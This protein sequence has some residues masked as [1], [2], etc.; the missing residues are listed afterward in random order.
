[1]QTQCK[2]ESPGFFPP[3]IC[4]PCPLW[5]KRQQQQQTQCAVRQVQNG[6]SR[7]FLK[8]NKLD[9]YIDNF[10]D[11][12]YDDMN[13]LLSMNNNEL[14][15]V[16]TETNIEKPGHIKRFIADFEILKSSSASSSGQ[17]SSSSS[18]SST[19][20]SKDS[21]NQ[22]SCT[23]SQGDVASINKSD[24]GDDPKNLPKAIQDMY[25]PNPHNEQLKFYN[26]LLF[27]LHKSSYDLISPVQFENYVMSQRHQRWSVE[28]E[29]KTVEAF[30]E[31]ATSKESLE[32]NAINIR[33]YTSVD[34]SKF[35]A[36]DT[37]RAE[38]TVEYVNILYSRLNKLKKLVLN[39]KSSLYDSEY[40]VKHWKANELM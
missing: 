15:S 22:E 14:M 25:I 4:F 30:F 39:F 12:G 17:T 24:H 26:A 28:K 36:K 9:V 6:G 27:S 20:T 10:E 18:A 1:M 19:S 11:V 7:E 13:Q 35:L 37:K 29:F 16:A 21:G 3:L 40:V 5:T 38:N 34:A 31:S 33:K 2:L 23:Q 32:G 8:Q